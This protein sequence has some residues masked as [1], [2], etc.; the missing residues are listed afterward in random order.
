MSD[1]RC[2]EIV[3]VIVMTLLV[4]F[5]ILFWGYKMYQFGFRQG[6]ADIIQK[7]DDHGLRR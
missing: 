5:A 4:G 7:I 3:L 1:D 2:T 6:Q